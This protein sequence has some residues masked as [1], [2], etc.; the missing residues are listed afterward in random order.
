MD[1]HMYMHKSHLMQTGMWGGRGDRARERCGD[2]ILW[3]NGERSHLSQFILISININWEPTPTEHRSRHSAG[4]KWS[5]K[6][7]KTSCRPH[8]LGREAKN[9]N[10]TKNKQKIKT[11]ALH[12]GL[13]FWEFPSSFTNISFSPVCK[14]REGGKC[15]LH[16]TEENKGLSEDCAEPASGS[17]RIQVTELL[18]QSFRH[19]MTPLLCKHLLRIQHC[20]RR[21]QRK[22]KWL[23]L[24]GPREIEDQAS[25]KK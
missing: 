1:T 5:T 11:E 4:S 25:K 9:P 19:N 6:A 22:K 10:Q 17:R 7:P 2:Q 16:L 12:P 15:Y 20:V 23:I 24:P 14:T 18:F 21:A 3:V 13:Q 8:G